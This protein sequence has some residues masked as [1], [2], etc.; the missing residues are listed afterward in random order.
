MPPSNLHE[1]TTQSSGGP[2][3]SHSR[4]RKCSTPTPA[5]PPVLPDEGS[6]DLLLADIGGSPAQVL[7]DF[8]HLHPCSVEPGY[9]VA[10]GPEP[11]RTWLKCTPPTPRPVT[12]EGP[13]PLPCFWVPS[14]AHAAKGI[15]TSLSPRWAGRRPETKLAKQ[16]SPHV[17]PPSVSPLGLVSSLWARVQDLHANCPLRP[18]CH[19]NP[20]KDPPA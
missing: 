1:G 15:W 16:A 6:P 18:F 11:R 4:E 7:D 5:L 17:C 13:R 10:Q 20:A 3:P 2:N 8:R 19:K 9:G 14:S 12:A